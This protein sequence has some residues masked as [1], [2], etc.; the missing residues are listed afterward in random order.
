MV[1]GAP[2]AASPSTPRASPCPRPLTSLGSQTAAALS[3]PREHAE[4]AGEAL[5]LEVRRARSRRLASTVAY[6]A[7]RPRRARHGTLACTQRPI[8]G[9]DGAAAAGGRKRG[10]QTKSIQYSPRG[11]LAYFVSRAGASRNGTERLYEW[12]ASKHFTN[13]QRGV[14]ARRRNMTNA[15]R[16]GEQPPYLT[17][18]YI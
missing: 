4:E 13:H 11:L 2:A 6:R 17:I 1:D 14:N 10:R 3:P 8:S 9:G 12:S 7:F 16:P 18:L 5:L 15:V